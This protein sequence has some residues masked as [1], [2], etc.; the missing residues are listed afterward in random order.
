MNALFLALRMLRRSWRSGEI[1]IL[2]W[3]LLIAVAGMTAVEAFTDRVQQA[4]ERQAN[5]L[6]G[7]D[8]VVH[9]DHPFNENLGQLAERLGLRFDTKTEFPSVATADDALQ[10]GAI[11]AVGSHYPLRGRL[12]ISQEIGGDI[13][14]VT[15][16]PDVG[17]AWLDQRML[18]LLGITVGDSV[19]L[20]AGDFEVSAVLQ[21]EPDQTSGFT[22]LAPRVMI[23]NEDLEATQLLQRGSRAKYTLLL[24]GEPV[25]LQAFRQDAKALLT[26]AQR[27][28]DV[29]QARP[30]VAIALERADRFLALAAQRKHRSRPPKSSPRRTTRWRT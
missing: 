3:A 14:E 19:S 7:A 15:S 20:G 11:K 25:Q 22:A 4:L 18:A 17:Q 16:G 2:F 10:L 6:L 29:K 30:Q 23:R 1:Q 5:D 24:A 26:P 13:I 9:S 27:I 28:E 21:Q 12:R 8:L